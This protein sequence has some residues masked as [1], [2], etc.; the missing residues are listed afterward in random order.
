MNLFGA[1]GK[2]VTIRAAWGGRSW[3]VERTRVDGGPVF[4]QSAPTIEA[5][6]NLALDNFWRYGAILWITAQ[7]RKPRAPSA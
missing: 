6:V 5:A 4:Q 7:Q 1:P 3:I 2:T